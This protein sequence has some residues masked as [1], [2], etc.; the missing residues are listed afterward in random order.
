[1]DPDFHRRDLWNAIQQHHFPE[2]ELGLQIFD[3]SFAKK[4]AFDILDATKIIPEEEVPVKKVGKLVLNRCVDNFFAETEQVAFCTQNIVPG[5]GFSDDPLLQGRNFSY[6]DTQLKRLGS[7]NFAQL[8]INA[9][10]CPMHLFQQDGHM[11]LKNP[12]SRINYSPNSSEE[13]QLVEQ[14]NKSID[15]PCS[16]IDGIKTRVRSESFSDHYSQ[17]RQFYISQTIVEQHHIRDAFVFELSKVKDVHIRRRMVSNLLHVDVVLAHAIAEGLGIK[18]IPTPSKAAKPTNQNLSASSALSI[19]KNKPR[20]FQGRT[21]GILL[22][23]NANAKQFYEL[24]TDILQESANLTII[25]QHSGDL[26]L[27]DGSIIMVDEKI[28]G[29]SSVLFDA[30]VLLI[31]E[32]SCQQLLKIAET[33]DF[34]MDAYSH[35]KYIAYNNA[36]MPLFDAININENQDEGCLKIIDKASVKNFLIACKN[37][38]YWE[39][40]I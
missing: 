40:A 34:L 6:L 8:P 12:K 15:A 2:W 33:K 29:A 3:E 10:R 11:T 32:K 38:R 26:R 18:D 13:Q 25:A 35:F 22:S 1:M 5:I 37:L 9:P 21:I 31:T 23:E 19:L 4:F 7:P 14:P 36:A 30:I 39:R 16:K 17:A 24:Q 20:N 27:D 28:K